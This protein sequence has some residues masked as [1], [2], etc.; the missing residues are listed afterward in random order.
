MDN[1]TKD[2]DVTKIKEQV[3]DFI[4]MNGKQ[5]SV[6]QRKNISQ[7]ADKSNKIIKNYF[8]S[9]SHINTQNNEDKENKEN[10]ENK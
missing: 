5:I 7:I 8:P 9:K 10:K 6:D 4:N 1:K 3:G 2:L